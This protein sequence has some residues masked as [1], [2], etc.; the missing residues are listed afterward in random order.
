M[1]RAA[2]D[3]ILLVDVYHEFDYPFEMV[4]AM[5][6]AFKPGGRLVFVEFRAEDQGLVLRVSDNGRGFD[7]EASSGGFVDVPRARRAALTSTASR[8][9]FAAHRWRARTTR[10]SFTGHALRDRADAR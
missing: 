10:D 1:P 2:V 5:I 4:E 8:R 6:S 7:A 3:L 9:R